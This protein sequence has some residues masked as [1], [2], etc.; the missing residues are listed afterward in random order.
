MTMKLLVKFA[1][2]AAMTFAAAGAFAVPITGTVDF[3]GDVVVSGTTIMFPGDERVESGTGTYAGVPNATP[4]AFT[5]F[6]YSP[7]AGP[8]APLLTFTVGPNTYSFSLLS[9]VV[10]ADQG[11]LGFLLSGNGTL[12]ATGFDNTPGTFF[13]STQGNRQSFSAQLSP[14]SVPEPAT[15][16]LLGLGLLGMGLARRRRKA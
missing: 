8:V 16:G 10:F 13:F 3:S 2:T 5:N 4:A 14:T 12:S 6:T 9:N 15:L 7:F 1:A 11:A